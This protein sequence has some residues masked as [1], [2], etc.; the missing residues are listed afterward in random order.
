MSLIDKITS[1]L[2]EAMKKRDQSAVE[3]LRLIKSE[4]GYKKIDKGDEL[5]DKELA[6]LLSSIENKWKDGIDQF[7]KGN[8][9]DLVEQETAK[10]EVL[11][12][13][14]PKKLTGEELNN[15]INEVIE[16]S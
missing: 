13:Y 11:Q 6:A 4:I 1:D 12:R 10:F 9:P 16:Q 2:K 7:K 5:D 14:L 15:I 8:R 3:A